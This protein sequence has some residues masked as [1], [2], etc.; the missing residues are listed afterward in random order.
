MVDRMKSTPLRPVQDGLQ[1]AAWVVP[2]AS[3]TEVVG[4]HGESLKIRV[5]AAASG[6]QANAAVIAFLRRRLGCPVTITTGKTSRNKQIHIE[7]SDLE[8]IAKVLGIAPG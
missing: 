7:S 5:A 1:L 3:R 6:G 4:L 2:G 8:G